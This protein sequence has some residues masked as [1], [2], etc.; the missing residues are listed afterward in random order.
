MSTVMIILIKNNRTQVR[1]RTKTQ[2]EIKK[3][4]KDSFKYNDKD[5]E[6]TIYHI[7][8][9]CARVKLQ[10]IPYM[11]FS[12][13]LLF[14]SSSFFFLTC[15]FVYPFLYYY[16]MAPCVSWL[17]CV[18]SLLPHTIIRVITVY[19]NVFSNS[20]FDQTSPTTMVHNENYVDDDD[21]DDDCRKRIY[22][23]D[24]LWI[25]LCLT[26]ESWSVYCSLTAF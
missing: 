5:D 25:L 26:D 1:K 8:K 3:R 17:M 9:C 23:P 2:S 11:R 14:V 13:L 15:A 19:R 12:L 7:R 21:L 22:S 24:Q 4:E 20:I 16:C 18:D 6:P 10:L